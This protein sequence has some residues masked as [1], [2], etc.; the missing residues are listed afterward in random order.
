MRV[1]QKAEQRRVAEHRSSLLRGLTGVVCEVGAG[2]GLNFARYPPQ[3][4]HVVAVEPEPTL[5]AHAVDHARRAP[6]PVEVREG[7]ADELPLDDNRC[8]A[9]VMSLVLCSVPN[10]RAALMEARRVLRPGGELRFYEHIRSERRW[11]GIGEDLLTPIW[12]RLAGGCH[13]NRDT[14]ASIG[15][16]GFDI[17]GPRRLRVQPPARPATHR[18]RSRPSHEP[19]MTVGEP[20]EVPIAAVLTSVGGVGL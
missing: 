5:R 13:L 6:V 11:V 19:A 20:M 3:V 10:Q 1:S 7:V 18:A 14:V 17:T 8:D 12:S 4:T 15:A 9:V 16:A 2:H